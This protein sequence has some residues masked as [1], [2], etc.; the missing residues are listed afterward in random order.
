MA[1]GAVC[2]AKSDIFRGV[3]LVMR[4]PCR[5]SRRY[6]RYLRPL[7]RDLRSSN[8]IMRLSEGQMIRSFLFVL[9]L[10]FSFSYR[11]RDALA[12]DSFQQRT[13]WMKT[14]TNQNCLT[15]DNI[16]R[17][18]SQ[19][20]GAAAASS[21]RTRLDI[22]RDANIHKDA[23]RRILQG[24]RTISMSEAL[25]ILSACGTSPH[26]HLLLFLSGGSSRAVDWLQSDL[27]LFFEDF[28][29][30]LP[31]ALEQHLGNQLHDIKPRWAKGTAHRVARLLGEHI[32]EL[33]RKDA[34]LGDIYAEHAGEANA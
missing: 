34:L 33:V 29:G 8:R 21:G 1:L 28:V 17:D 2:Q 25:R 22:A 3:V 5:Q 14:L 24:E 20:L 31:G 12:G 9:L 15:E 11:H 18:L 7:C 30:Q 6:Y 4:P 16:R 27:A 26:A 13:R 32:D 10:F 23:L 19:L